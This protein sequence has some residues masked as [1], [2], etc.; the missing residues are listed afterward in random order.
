MTCQTLNTQ[1]V[2]APIQVPR[3]SSGRLRSPE[4]SPLSSPSTS[5]KP[6]VTKS[7]FQIS[8][9]SE[10]QY[11]SKSKSRFTVIS[12]QDNS[13][14]QKREQ[15]ISNNNNTE[16]DT[17]DKSISSSEED[18]KS[19]DM[20]EDSLDDTFQNKPTDVQEKME[21]IQEIELNISE[22]ILDQQME[23]K[24]INNTNDHESSLPTKNGI[25]ISDKISN[26][27]NEREDDNIEMKIDNSPGDVFIDEDKKI[28]LDECLNI[29][30]IDQP[31]INEEVM[32]TSDQL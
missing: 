6:I 17:T 7:R 13:H 18:L 22:N 10:N 3:T 31:N 11:Q 19:I 14:Y 16:K 26:N 4:V 1:R 23:M 2:R 8:V 15:I 30:V 32:D 5:R 29:N 20:K 28:H 12:V 21:G 9:V 27:E 24:N 25:K